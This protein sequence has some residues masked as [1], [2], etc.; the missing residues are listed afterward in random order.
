M[1]VKR[2]GSAAAL[3]LLLAACCALTTVLVYRVFVGTE[4]GQAVDQAL[5]QRAAMAPVVVEQASEA[6]LSLFTLP[7]VLAVGAVP[8]VL[9]LLRRS[10]WHAGGALVLVVGANATTQL[11]KSYVFERPDLL[12]LGAPNSLPSGHTTVVASVFLGLALIAPPALRVPAALVGTAASLVVGVATVV[13][14]WHRLSDVAAAVLVAAAW[15]GVVLAAVV[16][17]PRRSHA[18]LAATP[19]VAGAAPTARRTRATVH[20]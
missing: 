16:L 17:R 11:L 7:V 12:A 4:L 13:A 3:G 9:A 15:A 20:R 19:A 2:R 14:G 1:T 10:P 5:L 18:M 8:A 6:V